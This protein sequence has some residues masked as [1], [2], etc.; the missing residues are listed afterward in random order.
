MSIAIAP[1]RV[2]ASTAGLYSLIYI[3]A[4]T[5][6]SVGDGKRV[7]R[8]SFLTQWFFFLPAVWIVGPYLHYGLFQIWL[9]TAVYGALATSL[10]TAVWADG[11]WKQI[12]I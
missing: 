12:K 7:M 11:K 1:L 10:I 4:Y 3:F 8:I 6:Y 2:V 5:L 9:V